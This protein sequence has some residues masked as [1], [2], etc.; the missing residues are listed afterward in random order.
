MRAA[1]F[2]LFAFLAALTLGAAAFTPNEDIVVKVRKEGPG[3]AI[4]VDCPVDAPLQ[5]VWEVMTDYPAD[6]E[7]HLEHPVQRHRGNDRQR[8]P[9]APEGEGLARAADLDLR[10]DA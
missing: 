8:A 4:D 9:R 10:H 3:V 7:F 6:A 1:E 5:I 2:L